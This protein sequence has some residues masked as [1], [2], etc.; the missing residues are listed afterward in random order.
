MSEKNGISNK[1]TGLSWDAVR[2]EAPE[3][4]SFLPR[5]SEETFVGR[6]KR[7]V[8]AFLFVLLAVLSFIVVTAMAALRWDEI[9]DVLLNAMPDSLRDDYSDSDAERAVRVLLA[10]IGGLGL[11]LTLG[12]VLSASSLLT[13]R[14][15]SARVVLVVCTVVHLPLSFIAVTVRDGGLLDIVL[16]SVA[17][18]CLVVAVALVC[19]PVVSHWLR[20]NEQR[21]STPFGT[22][23]S[24]SD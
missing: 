16:S 24:K 9:Q 4:P 11:V 7:T 12:Q 10:A 17:A 21:R 5:I 19:T 6:P 20:Q 23:L 8:V 22:P 14:A 1:Q 3:R 18:A 15:S 2:T 13:R